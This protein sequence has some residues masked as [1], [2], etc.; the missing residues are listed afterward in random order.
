MREKLFF[1]TWTTELNQLGT[2]KTLKNTRPQLNL[3][4]PDW[5]FP[6]AQWYDVSSRHEFPVGV[7]DIYYLYIYLFLI[8]LCFVSISKSVL[9]N[10]W[11]LILTWHSALLT[12]FKRRYINWIIIINIIIIMRMQ[13]IKLCGDIL[14]M[15]EEFTD[16]PQNNR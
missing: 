1:C 13:S 12:V 4:F 14:T 16:K 5:T 6:A 9:T 8:V 15:L 11:L 2:A 7:R 10:I 3:I